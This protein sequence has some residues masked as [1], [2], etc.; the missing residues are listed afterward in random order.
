MEKTMK[1]MTKKTGLVV[2][3]LMFAGLGACASDPKDDDGNGQ[4]D[5]PIIIADGNMIDDLEDGDDA[6]ITTAE[7]SGDWYTFN[8]ATSGEQNPDPDGEFVPE[9][10]G[11]DGSSYAVHTTGSGWT[12]WG[13]GIGLDLNGAD[14]ADPGASKGVFDA[15]GF[16][17]IAFWAKGNVSL[18]VMLT[19]FDVLAEDE[20]GGCVPG[21]GDGEACDNGHGSSVTLTDEWAQYA[22]TFDSIAQEEGWGQEIDFSAADIVSILFQTGPNDTFDYWIDEIGFY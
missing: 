14:P 13:A 7:R 20:G 9:S 12:E 22:V 21:T 16:E 5:D 4:V 3:V 15:T 11:P 19:V 18:W 6:I 1:K 10:G 17:G 8:D 2:L